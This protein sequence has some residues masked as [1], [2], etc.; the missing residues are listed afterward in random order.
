MLPS[1][2]IEITVIQLILKMIPSRELVRQ[3]GNLML[4]VQHPLWWQSLTELQKLMLH[5]W[6]PDLMS[7]GKSELK[8]E[9]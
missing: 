3:V 8:P 4:K 9:L 5:L 7:I 1:R 2:V 6:R